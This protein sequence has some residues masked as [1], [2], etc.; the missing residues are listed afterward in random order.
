MSKPEDPTRPHLLYIVWGFPPSRGGGVYRALATANEAVR[1][2]FRVTVLTAEAEV[3]RRYTGSDEGL[4]DLLD[5]DVSVVRIPFSWPVREISVT[6]DGSLRDMLRRLRR[7]VVA[8]QGRIPFPETNYGHWRRPL[9]R[10]ALTI[11][12]RDPIDLVLATANPN[13]TFAAAFALAQQAS[14]PYVLDH[15]DAWLLDV[16]SGRILKSRVSRE[17]RW[18]R[19]IVRDAAEL[20]FVNEPIR[21]WHRARFPDASHRMHVVPNGWDEDAVGDVT[22]PAPPN[23]SPT[24][25]YL[26]TISA[27][28]P[29]PQ[30]TEAWA[31]ARDELPEGAR[32]VLAGHAGYFSSPDPRITSALD[33]ATARGI[34]V[35]GPV[36]KRE[37]ASFYDTIDVL[38]LALGDGRYVT[39]GKVYEYIATGRPIVAV[40]SPSSAATAVLTGYPGA[41]QTTSTDPSDVRAALLDAVAVWRATTSH[42]LAARAEVA[43]RY[44]R[45]RVLA[46]ALERLRRVISK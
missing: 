39:S 34:E 29:I 14:I 45:D 3:F 38:V 24:F 9:T 8:L 41:V 18:E 12:R 35:R 6:G 2:G 23:H 30:L 1:A 19:R 37:V 22:P 26:G 15:R 43:A 33:G 10:A 27:K 25:G 21:D 32:L 42:D 40:F 28:V 11:H 5:P 7:K 17:A 20:W 13:V 31:L 44:R 46:P 36:P 4:I 16:F